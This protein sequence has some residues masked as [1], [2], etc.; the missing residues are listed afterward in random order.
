[1]ASKPAAL[2]IE[3][4]GSCQEAFFFFSFLPI[5]IESDRTLI[6]YVDP[7]GVKKRHQYIA[8]VCE[9]GNEISSV[10]HGPLSLLVRRN[11]V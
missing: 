3:S 10:A 8:C 7:L 2:Q 5:F 9:S 6:A 1:V 4:R 11:C